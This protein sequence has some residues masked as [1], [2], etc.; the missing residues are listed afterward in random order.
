M[1][2]IYTSAFNIVKNKFS[3]EEAF[4]NYLSFAEEVIVSTRKDNEDSTIEVLNKYTNKYK[5]FKY[6]ISNDDISHPYFHGRL[7]DLA[8]QSC[9]QEFCIGLDIDELVPV[10]QKYNWI[11]LARNLSF[12]DFDAYLVPILNLWG[13]Y[14]TIR[15]DKD[16]NYGDKWAIHKNIKGKIKRGPVK[17]GIRDD[18][19]IDVDKSDTCELIYENGDLV[20]SYPIITNRN[21]NLNQY[22]FECM[23]KI[24]IYHIGYADFD[25]RV[26][27]N[28]TFW[29]DQLKLRSGNR[30]EESIDKYT[31]TNKDILLNKQLI[32]HNLPLW[33]QS[34]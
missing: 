18:G 33:N 27:I 3:Y 4:D 21:G 20:R 34:L 6:V 1:F 32:K 30:Q 12:C 15:W 31:P 13:S 11:S 2:S 7:R 23:N 14:E 16:F 25:R 8:L 24:F 26:N 5:K 17:F 22:L 10:W 28:K 29:Y 9:S 19:T